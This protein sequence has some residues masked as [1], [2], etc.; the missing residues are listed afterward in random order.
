MALVLCPTTTMG[1]DRVEISE[2]IPTV[3]AEPRLPQELGR[4]IFQMAAREDRIKT[5]PALMKVAHRVR[6]WIKQVV[7]DT[8]VLE[9]EDYLTSQTPWPHSLRF[10]SVPEAY[11]ALSALTS[12]IRSPLRT[13]MDFHHDIFESITHLEF[14]NF[15]G[16]TNGQW[17]DGNNYGKEAIFEFLGKLLEECKSLE[18]LILSE[19]FD[20]EEHVNTLLH[21]TRR[22]LRSDGTVEGVTG[23]NDMWAHSEKILQRR[24]R[25]RALEMV[26][27][28][29]L[30]DAD[31][32]ETL[33][34]LLIAMEAR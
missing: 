17:V 6:N 15:L 23:E 18:I 8:V 3:I 16:E 13:R 28:N 4:I 29:F 12:A 5:L 10:P 33:G 22:L 1:S 11:D 32:D 7:Y 34:E 27:R 31:T 20:F 9:D 26:S 25:K 14:L 21:N 19:D 30:V 24:R 2:P